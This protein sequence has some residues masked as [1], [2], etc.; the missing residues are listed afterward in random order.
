MPRVCVVGSANVDYTVALPRLPSPGET[1]SGGTLL[2][3]LG[4]KG[5]NQAMAARRLGGEVRMIGCVGDDA[6]G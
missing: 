6:D 1:V 2:V 4:G 5:A 3:N